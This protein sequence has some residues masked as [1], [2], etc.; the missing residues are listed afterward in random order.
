MY[1]LNEFLWWIII[2]LGKEVYRQWEIQVDSNYSVKFNME[3]CIDSQ[4]GQESYLQVT[5]GRDEENNFLQVQG[6]SS[7]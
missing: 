2:G 3:S 7:V 6:W 4:W 5:K 1:Q